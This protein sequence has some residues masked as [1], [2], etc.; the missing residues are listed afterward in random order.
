MPRIE[1]INEKSEE[2][3]AA[4]HKF[5]AKPR[6]FFL[7]SG[8]NGNGKSFTAQAIFEKFLH[9][10]Y[11]HQFWNASMLKNEW[12]R[13]HVEH[14]H[15]SYL[16]SKMLNAPLLIID[17]LGFKDPPPA[18]LEFLYC[19]F[20]GRYENRHK[21]A[22]MITTNLN[23]VDVREKFGDAILSRIASGICIRWD[24]RDRRGDGF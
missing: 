7:I 4:V 14:G 21:H 13:I 12:V 17:D 18:F 16:L 15:T 22:T 24:G 2:F 19:I 11:D 10:A 3:M 9:P 20:E 23:S 6:G 1:D 8:S 5:V